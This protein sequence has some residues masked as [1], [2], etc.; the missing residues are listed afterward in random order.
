MSRREKT[1]TWPWVATLDLPDGWVEVPAGHQRQPLL[2]SRDPY[3]RAAK[4]LV[5]MGSIPTDMIKRTQLY[6]SHACST[7]Q[8]G[9]AA[10]G[11]VRATTPADSILETCWVA[12]PNRS[13]WDSVEGMARFATEQ[14]PG[15]MSAT[16]PWLVV[17]AVLGSTVRFR[18]HQ[19]DDDGWVDEVVTYW[20][21]L[22]EASQALSVAGIYHGQP[23]KHWDRFLADV[24]SMVATVRLSRV[25]V[26]EAGG[27]Q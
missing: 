11:R 1:P 17:P 10:A 7:G 3:F 13:T 27:Q 19:E 15:A 20:V 23:G 8:T 18:R 14:T 26:T 6:L 16:E 24:D 21:W 12:G 22:T 4:Q 9:L 5:D 25:D 2:P